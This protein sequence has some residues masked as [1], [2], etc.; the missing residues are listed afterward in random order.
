[1]ETEKA[2]KAS[3]TSSSLP[4]TLLRGRCQGWASLERVVHPFFQTLKFPAR[5]ALSLRWVCPRR[6]DGT[7]TVHVPRP[8][9]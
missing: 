8:W 7:V 2:D 5:M 3:L 1:M 6:V 4:M 9:G